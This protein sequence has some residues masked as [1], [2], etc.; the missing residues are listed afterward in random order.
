[1]KLHGLTSK[2]RFSCSKAHQVEKAAKLAK[3]AENLREL[4]AL[5]A[6]DSAD[7]PVDEQTEIDGPSTAEATGGP[8]KEDNDAV[9]RVGQQQTASLQRPD[10]VRSFPEEPGNI[11]LPVHGDIVLRYGERVPSDSGQDTTLKGIK[12]RT[13]PGADVIAP[14]DGKVVFSG[15]FRSYG[16]ILIIDHGGRYHTLLAGL[17]RIRAVVGQWV[18]A[19]EPVATMDPQSSK[20]PELYLELRRTGQPIN[21]LPWLAEGE[22]RA[23]G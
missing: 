1:L 12:I 23:R 8:R 20:E 2:S 13:R 17:H 14:F 21:P 16:Q 9:S 5:A 7:R 4:M 18:L 6:R 11:L 10:T 22:Q 15:N 3:Q 19:G